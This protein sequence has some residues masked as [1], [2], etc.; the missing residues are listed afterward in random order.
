MKFKSFISAVPVA[1]ILLNFFAASAQS[2]NQRVLVVYNA[3]IA[4]SRDVAEYYRAARSI[5]AA[6]MCAIAPPSDTVV[7]QAEYEATVKAPMRACLDTL[8]RRNVLYVVLTYGTPFVLNVNETGYAL[9]SAIADIWD[10]VSPEFPKL[11]DAPSV[12]QGY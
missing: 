2:L 10:D 8:G 5:P 3:G 1:A 9:D 11:E 6:N 7:T 12:V 4:D